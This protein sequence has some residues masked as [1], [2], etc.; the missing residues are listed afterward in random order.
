MAMMAKQARGLLWM[1]MVA[2]VLAVAGCGDKGAAGGKS[3]G[4]AEAA[5]VDPDQALINAPKPGDLYAAE[6]SAFSTADFEGHDGKLYGLMKVVGADANKVVVITENAASEEPKV[7][8]QDILGDLSNIEFDEEEKIDIVLP[9]LK[10]AWDDG[11]IYEVRR[12]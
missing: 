3:A 4:G 9:E 5:E 1:A 8:S 7:A 6:L 12:R 10:K 2:G 11:R